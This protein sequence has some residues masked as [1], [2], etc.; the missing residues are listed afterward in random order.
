MKTETTMDLVYAVLSP[1]CEKEI[2]S[3]GWEIVDA[4]DYVHEERVSIY[5]PRDKEK[6][7]VAI[8][9]KFDLLGASL[10]ARLN[11]FT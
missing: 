6:E 8:L 7:Y 1:E 11:Q 4:S 9:K 3:L 5:Y 2:K 10:S